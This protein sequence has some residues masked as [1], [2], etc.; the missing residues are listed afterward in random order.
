MI[1]DRDLLDR[2]E[3]L[4][5]DRWEGS[6]CRHTLGD[7]AADRPNVRGAR[8]NPPGTP[9]IYTSLI[10][11]TAVAEGDH[12]IAVNSFRPSIKRVLH[13]LRV[14]LARVIDL[15]SFD[16]LVALGPSEEDFRSDDHAACQHIGGAVAWLGCDGMLVPSLRHDG[17]NLVVLPSNQGADFVFE[18]IKSEEIAGRA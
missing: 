8:W 4:G 7:S 14:E 17:V 12:L 5:A 2:L 13:E 18:L 1:H 6:V 3:Q 16:R 9:A 11:D 10:G 15:S